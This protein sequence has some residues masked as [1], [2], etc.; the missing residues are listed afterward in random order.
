VPNLGIVIFSF[1]FVIKSKNS[2]SE[3]QIIQVNNEKQLSDFIKFPME[4]YKNNQNY[5]P[6]LINDEKNI[7]NPKENPALAYSEAKQF[8]AYKNNKLAGRIAVMINYKE[9]KEL[10]IEKVRFGWLDFID[11]EEVSKALINE[12]IKFA[13]E[14]KHQKNRRTYG[15]YQSRQSRYADFWV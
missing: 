15:I 2:M 9:A 4:L 12:A 8:L 3:V 10:G 6:S 14:K 1:I 13:Q 11:D 7:W 5:V